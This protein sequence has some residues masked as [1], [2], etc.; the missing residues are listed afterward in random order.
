MQAAANASRGQYH[1]DKEEGRSAE[2]RTISVCM[3]SRHDNKHFAFQISAPQ[4]RISV[5]PWS[6][7]SDCLPK[8]IRPIQ[9]LRHRARCFLY[10]SA[11]LRITGPL[12]W[13]M[14]SVLARGSG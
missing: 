2:S 6:K 5:A 3:A 9:K 1:G 11:I 4:I 10:Q 13:Y 7:T 8:F 14:P 12:V